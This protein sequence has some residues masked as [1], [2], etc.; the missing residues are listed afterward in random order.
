MNLKLSDKQQLDN[1]IN[2]I[3]NSLINP[4]A[5]DDSLK[6]LLQSK[7]D[8]DFIV[9]SKLIAPD[10]KLSNEEVKKNSLKAEKILN[11]IFKFI[12]KYLYTLENVFKKVDNELQAITDDNLTKQIKSKVLIPIKKKQGE[13]LCSAHIAVNFQIKTQ[14]TIYKFSKKQASI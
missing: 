6:D 2:L 5:R 11:K 7:I 13:T 10:T 8:K 4:E 3:V 9:I 1:Q 12:P 14:Q